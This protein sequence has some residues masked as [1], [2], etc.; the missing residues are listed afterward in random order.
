MRSE[1]LYFAYALMAAVAGASAAVQSASIAKLQVRGGKSFSALVTILIATIFLLV[2]FLIESR[3]RPPNFKGVFIDEPI[4]P[5]L[6]GLP[7]AF[8][9]ITFMF[10][11]PHLGVAVVLCIMVTS[12]LILAC[13]IDHFGLFGVVTR[14]FTWQR[15]IG[16]ILMVA[17]VVIIGFF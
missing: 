8:I 15:G 3:L 16:C 11:V 5:W 17:G 4:N 6:S 10:A 7:T 2:Y 12:Q 9:L 13:I 1:I 14:D